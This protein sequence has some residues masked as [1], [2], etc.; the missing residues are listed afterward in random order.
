MMPSLPGLAPGSRTLSPGLWTSLTIVTLIQIVATAT[1]LALTALAPAVAET[2]GIGAYTIGYQISLLYVAGTVASAVAGT[3]VARWGATHVQA[4][5]L[6]CFAVG[7]LGLASANVPAIIAASIIIGF[8]YGLNNPA[9]SQLLSRVTPSRLRNLVFSMKQSGVPLGGIVA[10]FVFPAIASVAGWRW[11]LIA[12]LA[13]PVLMGVAL[14]LTHADAPEEIDRTARLRTGLVADQKR[15]WQTPA[16]RAL[17][18][19]GMS[20]SALQLSISAFAVVTLVE[21]A[22]WGIVA[23]GSIAA[24]MQAAGAICRVVWGAAADRIGGGF[25]ALAIIGVLSASATASLSMMAELPSAVTVVLFIVVG[26]TAIGWN[27]VLLAETARH[28]PRQSVGAITGGVLVYTFIGVI[29]GPSGFAAI[30]SLTDSY[31]T[32]FLVFAACGLIGASVA[33]GAHLG[34]RRRAAIEDGERPA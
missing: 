11:A 7:Y 25:I 24:A 23:A 13:G 3:L 9:S 15:I 5:T 20:F 14:A 2:L 30:Y 17:S 29:F 28:A 22:G 10:A 1:L 18:L 16:L 21:V 34:E 26:T 33:L 32:A 27:G 12:G 4:L 31:P 6:V 19:V 8:G